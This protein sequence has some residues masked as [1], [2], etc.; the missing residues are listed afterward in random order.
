MKINIKYLVP[1][2]LAI[3]GA[4]VADELTPVPVPEQI[5]GL[6]DWFLAH[7]AVSVSFLVP[8]L[9]YV[10]QIIKAIVA[11]VG[12]KIPA[13]YT[14]GV[15]ALVAFLGL[16][17]VVTADGKIDGSDWSALIIALLSAVGAFFGYKPLFSKKSNL[18]TKA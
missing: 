7:K 9:T 11:G 3:A 16:A 2:F 6:L 10:V 17:A 8:V 15:L 4:A 13:K 14:P 12:D 18:A 5:P 1:W